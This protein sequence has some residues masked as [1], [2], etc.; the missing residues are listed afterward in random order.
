MAKIT[1]S[2]S[3]PVDDEAVTEFLHKYVL[4]SRVGAARKLRMG[5]TGWRCSTP[6]GSVQA[7]LST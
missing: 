1:I 3:I 6:N 7:A 5:E 2:R 4:Q